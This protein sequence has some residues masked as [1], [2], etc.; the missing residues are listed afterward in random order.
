MNMSYCRFRNTLEAL[1]DC[2]DNMC[3]EQLSQDEAEAFACMVLLCNRIAKQFEDHDYS[4]LLDC[5][6]GASGEDDE[7]FVAGCNNC[8]I[9]VTEINELGL[10]N[11]CA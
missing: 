6:Y 5:A 2:K 4:D 1:Q 9:D 3:T 11:R 7:R 10:C 8:G